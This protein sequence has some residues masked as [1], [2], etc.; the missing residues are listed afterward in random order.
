MEE[1]PGCSVGL[2]P[3]LSMVR[4][5]PMVSSAASAHTMH[6]STACFCIGVSALFSF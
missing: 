3:R 1:S 2:L 4:V 6:T 5:M